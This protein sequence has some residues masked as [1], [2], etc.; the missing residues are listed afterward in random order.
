MASYVL[1]EKLIE[2]DIGT[3]VETANIK[4][5][6]TD[7][8]W[9]YS[10]SYRASRHFYEKAKNKTLNYFIDVHRDSV[11]K[12]ATT[13]SKGKEKYAKV[14]FIVGLE[15]D[16]Y[17]KNLALAE[18]INYRMS[19]KLPGISRGISKK[20]GPNVNGIYNQDLHPNTLVIEVGGVENSIEEVYNTMEILATVLSE[21]IEV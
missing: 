5:Y 2:K 15:H 14:M 11:G 12:D 4:Q 9:K 17:K 8:N 3:I 18:D 6:M 20:S 10:R 7:N 21:K 19:M 16:N 13:I 1:K